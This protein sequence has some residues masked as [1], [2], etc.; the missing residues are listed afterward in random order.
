MDVARGEIWWADLPDA[1]DSSPA[2]TRPVL[3]LQCQTFNRSRIQTVITA[4]IT[5]NMALA[6]APGNVE[7]GVGESGLPR[8]SVVNVTQ[9]FTV[10]RRSLRSRSG[11]LPA[12]TMEAVS[13]GLRLAMAL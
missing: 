6:A 9:L 1:T 5:S 4:V 8:P 10:D 3:I 12:P 13:D 7:L 2:G 11:R